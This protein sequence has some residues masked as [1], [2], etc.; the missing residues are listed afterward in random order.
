MKDSQNIK[1]MIEMMEAAE[2]TKETRRRMRGSA[3]KLEPS[4]VMSENFNY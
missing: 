3:R 4:S 1:N 2:A